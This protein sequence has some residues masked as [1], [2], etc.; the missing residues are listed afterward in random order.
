MHLCWLMFLMNS[1]LVSETESLS[2][3]SGLLIWSA[4]WPVNSR[5]LFVQAYL[6]LGLQL[7]PFTGS[8]TNWAISPV[9]WASVLKLGSVALLS[10]GSRTPPQSSGLIFHKAVQV[11]AG[12]FLKETITT[13]EN[14][15]CAMSQTD[16]SV[17]PKPNGAM[18]NTKFGVHWPGSIT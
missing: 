17:L 3:T 12:Q 1:H 13:N 15:K 11:S 9:L 16:G 7:Y 14:S 6:V 10:P 4:G 2:G 18:L 5:V 8:F